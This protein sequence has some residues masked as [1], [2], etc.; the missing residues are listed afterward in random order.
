MDRT[1]PVGHRPLPVQ[2]N[3]GEDD[4]THSPEP[5]DADRDAA[6]LALWPLARY[7]HPR[8]DELT[9]E[10]RQQWD[11]VAAAIAAARTERQQ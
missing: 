10:E 4:M 5:T 9:G 8:P 1:G 7:R 3:P 6:A 11:R 2:H